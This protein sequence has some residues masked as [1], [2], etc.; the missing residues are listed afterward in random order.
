MILYISLVFM[1]RFELEKGLQSYK[2]LRT[3]NLY[4]CILFLNPLKLVLSFLPAYTSQ[5]PAFK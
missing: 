1:L 2:A 5:Y 4:Q 3:Y